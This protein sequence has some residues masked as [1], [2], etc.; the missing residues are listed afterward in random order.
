MVRHESSR[1]RDEDGCVKDKGQASVAVNGVQEVHNGG[2]RCGD[3]VLSVDGE[4]RKTTLS[5]QS[6]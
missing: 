1:R 2:Q 5:P 4:R 6:F 3:V